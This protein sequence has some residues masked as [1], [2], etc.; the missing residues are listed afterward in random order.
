[1]N[2]DDKIKMAFD[3]F[4]IRYTLVE[5]N[6]YKCEACGLGYVDFVIDDKAYHIECLPRQELRVSDVESDTGHAYWCEKFIPNHS[7][8]CNC[9][10][11]NTPDP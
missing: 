4:G 1:M 11:D 2:Q 7:Y 3:K 10:S 9:G 8:P 6:R 5:P